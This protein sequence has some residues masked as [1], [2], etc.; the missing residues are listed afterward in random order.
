MEIDIPR[1]MFAA[2]KSGSGKTLLTCAALGA[3]KQQKKDVAAFKCGPDYVD[4]MFHRTVQGITAENLDTWFSGEEG[5][6]NLFIQLAEGHDL[7]VMEGVMGL[8]DG[9]G[10]VREEGSAHHLAKVTDTP[11]ILIVDVHGMGMS[12]I[13]LIRG[14]LD[15]DRE[16]IGDKSGKIAGVILN[17]ISKM[18]F[19]TM[20][21][22]LEEQ[23]SVPVAGYFPT[24]K[25]LHLESRHLGLQ[26]PEEIADLQSQLQMAAD[27]F[28]ETVD[29]DLLIQIAESAPV[30]QISEEAVTEMENPKQGQNQSEVK[31]NHT[32][33]PRLAV[34]RDEAFCFYYE[35]NLRCLEQAG[36]EL[37]EF[38]P[39]HDEKLPEQ[40]QGLLLGGGYPELYA[41]MLSENVSMREEIRR[42]IE[43]GMPSLAEC[44]GFMYLHESLTDMEGN[45]YEMAGVIPGKT[46]YKG[47]LVRFGYVEVQE[48]KFFFLRDGETIKGHEFHYYDSTDNGSACIAKK[49][50]G[51]RNW[52]CIHKSGRNF[53]GYPHL[54]YPSNP[55]FV[56]TF[57]GSM[58]IYQREQSEH[59]Q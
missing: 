2:P 52:D 43:D 37:V 26:L 18:F 54:Y 12:M 35:A 56:E 22:L 36:A 1:L 17:R 28:Q 41:R 58:K 24:R 8:F 16:R 23:L 34:A 13:P 30:L 9:L 47:K 6:R 7:A 31:E 14:F 50:T 4:P 49:T 44:G 40:I 5:T 45:S 53:W 15:Y 21:P 33:K 55:S 29:M 10:G 46:E 32:T 39:L 19:D 57:V 3:L 38:S 59:E 51:T 11:I 27:Q 48:K 20:K 42:A 25:D